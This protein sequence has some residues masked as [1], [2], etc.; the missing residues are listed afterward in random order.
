MGV[1]ASHIHTGTERN[2]QN[3]EDLYN[4]TLLYE[5]LSFSEQIGGKTTLSYT[6][7]FPS[8]S[9]LFISYSLI[10]MRQDKKKKE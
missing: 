10:K 3:I 7:F 5:V 8:F 6:L 1:H 9:Q 2:K 4:S